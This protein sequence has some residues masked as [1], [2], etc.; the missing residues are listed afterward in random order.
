[1]SHETCKTGSTATSFHRCFLCSR[2]V[3]QPF[4]PLIM[5]GFQSVTVLVDMDASNRKC[6]CDVATEWFITTFAGLAGSSCPAGYVRP[7]FSMQTGLFAT[8]GCVCVRVRHPLAIPFLHFD[9]SLLRAHTAHRVLFFCMSHSHTVIGRPK[10]LQC[11][12]TVRRV[13]WWLTHGLRQTWNKQLVAPYRVSLT[14]LASNCSPIRRLAALKSQDGFTRSSEDIMTRVGWGR[15]VSLLA[16]MLLVM[17]MHLV[18]TLPPPTAAETGFLHL[19]A[20][21]KY[22]LPQS[23]HAQQP[24]ELG[25]V[26]KFWIQQHTLWES[27]TSCLRKDSP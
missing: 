19:W 6:P 9:H 27:K 24:N 14:Q 22:F 21:R 4:V 15:G 5:A 26:F 2:Q 10:R 12:I 25:S 1:M 18:Q 3:V 16:Q 11:S 7:G 23:R 13:W 8:V 20:R 17:V